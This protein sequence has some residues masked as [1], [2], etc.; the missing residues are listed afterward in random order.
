VK[1]PCLEQAWDE[2]SHLPDK[3]AHGRSL[4]AQK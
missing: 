3:Q 4:C 1:V 2:L